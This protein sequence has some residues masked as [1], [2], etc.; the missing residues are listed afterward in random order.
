MNDQIIYWETSM[1]GMRVLGSGRRKK[2]ERRNRGE[3]KESVDYHGQYCLKQMDVLIL[4]LYLEKYSNKI[5]CQTVDN[6]AK[7]NLYLSRIL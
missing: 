7:S 3:G 2:K 6:F 4:C 1:M 5:F